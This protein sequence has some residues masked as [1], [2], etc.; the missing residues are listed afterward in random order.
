MIYNNIYEGTFIKRVN[1]FIAHVLINGKEEVVHVKN[2]GRCKELFIEGV[3]VFL[4]KSDNPNRKTK[5]SLIGIVK[6][7]HMINIDSQVPNA[8]IEEA[9]KNNKITGFE[10][11][12]FI[13]REQT[14]GHSRFDIYY[15]TE[16]KKG[17]IEIKGVTLE[18]DGISMFPDAPTTRGTKHVKELIAGQHEGFS[19]SIIFLIQM[20]DVHTF[21]PNHHTDPD[22]ASALKEAKE[23]GVH[24]RC[25]T[26]LVTKDSIEVFE[27][28][29]NII[30]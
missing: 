5:Y 6:D 7:Q 8:V 13:K 25:F 12:T 29:T 11:L 28:M 19:N 30:L 14:Y 10:A 3:K 18:N 20:K 4:E 22:F 15:E 24:I 2:T 16:S 27:E 23:A 1:R 17:Y 21:T 26:S 9:I